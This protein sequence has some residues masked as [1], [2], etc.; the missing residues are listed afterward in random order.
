MSHHHHAI[1][2]IELPVDDVAAAKAFYAA[3]FGWSFTDY[4]P[5]YAGI[6]HP[7][8]PGE[9]VGGLNGA[10]PG[11]PRGAGPFVLLYST[12]LDAS[13][14]AVGAAGGTVTEGPY[15]FPGGRRFHFTDPAG[16]PLGVW[17][18]S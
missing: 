15:E 8:E 11:G 3:A 9:E 16:N 12:D 14:A 2:Y 5:E 17:A 6:R 10:S 18:E 13:V 1:D 4:G 7:T